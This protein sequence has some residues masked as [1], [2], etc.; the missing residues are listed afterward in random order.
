MPDEIRLIPMTE[1][2]KEAFL[3]Q[4]DVVRGFGRHTDDPMIRNLAYRHANDWDLFVNN[5][6]DHGFTLEDIECSLTQ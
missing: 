1:E 4:S 2:M 3:H 5:L 6:W